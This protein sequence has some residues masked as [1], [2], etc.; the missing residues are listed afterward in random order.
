MTLEY[1]L[2][3]YNTMQTRVSQEKVVSKQDL[4]DEADKMFQKTRQMLR[5][6]VDAKKIYEHLQR[7][8][9]DFALAYPT[10]LARMALGEYSAVALSKYV[11]WVVENPWSTEETW[12]TAQAMY[13]RLL[14]SELCPNATPAEIN[15]VHN[16]ALAMLKAESKRFNDALGA[17]N[18][19]KE[20]A[21]KE[22]KQ[23]LAEWI[24]NNKAD[25]IRRLN[26]ED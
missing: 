4:L 13:I 20:E 21:E 18:R 1:F 19:E 2:V 10:V 9:H 24:K 14:F 6:K 17:I 5:A 25:I 7:N 11:D 15:K 22:Y 26:Q 23:E 3:Y 8:H 12:L 16:N